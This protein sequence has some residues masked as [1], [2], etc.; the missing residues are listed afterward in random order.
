MDIAHRGMK[1]TW[2]HIAISLNHR[3]N[4]GS[5]ATRRNSLLQPQVSPEVVDNATQFFRALGNKPTGDL[6]A[7]FYDHRLDFCFQLL[8]MLRRKCDLCLPAGIPAAGTIECQRR[9]IGCKKG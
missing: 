5:I 3:R 6:A 1:E 8:N 7:I 2:T 4:P 9:K